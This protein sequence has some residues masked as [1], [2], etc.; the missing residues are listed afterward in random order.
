MIDKVNMTSE[1]LKKSY[2][3]ELLQK[4]NFVFKD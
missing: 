1:P 3:E 2:S 4:N